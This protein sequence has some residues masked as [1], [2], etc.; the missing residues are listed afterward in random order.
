M[1][2]SIRAKLTIWCV[3]VFAWLIAAFALIGYSLFVNALQRDTDEN[4]KQMTNTL[5]ASIRGEQNDGEKKKTADEL[6]N[7]T[8]D[9]FKF[10]DYQFAVFT[11]DDKFIG[12]TTEKELPADLHSID[13]EKYGNV[14]LNGQIARVQMSPF[15]I[16][17]RNYKLYTFH[18][19]EEDLALQSRIRQTFYVLAP[20]LLLLSGLGGYF[21]AWAGLKPIAEIVLRAKKISSTNLSERLPVA[22]A[23]DEIGLMAIVFNDLLDRLDRDFEKQKQFMADASHE[24]RTPLAIICGESEVA[25]SKERAGSTNYQE[26]LQIVNDEG[27]RLT[28]IVED[29]FTLARADSGEIKPK[30]EFLYADELLGD[31]VR[32]V[33]TLADKR[34][35]AI[36]FY[37][38][39]MPVRGDESLLR[40]LFLNLL[41][42]AVK[43]NFDNGHI[44][45][46]AAG[47]SIEI[48]NSGDEIPTEQ[49]TSVFERFYRVEK[50]RSKFNS[51]VTSGAGLGLS[52][53]KWIADLHHANL[54]YSRKDNAENVFT[55]IFHS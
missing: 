39:E 15:L 43:Y 11:N 38:E 8:L 10:R 14:T 41:D 23:K 17:D 53:A 28:K 1:F 54:A 4:L 50:S 32:L 18:S 9:E 16:E 6:V 45:I 12:A 35:I 27:R 30:F 37:T 3:C 42:N 20:L 29:L 22:N 24:L 52:I 21:L 7:E 19:L 51:S 5:S 2:S 33:R 34:N 55:V 49:R 44:K 47:K 26:S 48:R 36:D 13:N 46:V 25:L 31:C 40:R